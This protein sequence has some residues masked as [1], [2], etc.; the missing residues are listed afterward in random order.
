MPATAPLSSSFPTSRGFFSGRPH[1]WDTFSAAGATPPKPKGPELESRDEVRQGTWSLNPSWLDVEPAAPSA[2]TDRESV[3][4]N[5]SPGGIGLSNMSPFTR[6]GFRLPAVG[7]GDWRSRPREWSL[8]AVGSGRR[9]S[10]LWGMGRAVEED[11]EEEYIQTRSGATSRRHSVAAFS[12]HH[13]HVGFSAPGPETASAA[14]SSLRTS[15]RFNDDE[16]AADLNSLH[17]NLEAVAG[18]HHQHGDGPSLSQT[19]PRMSSLPNPPTS[20][21]LSEVYEAQASSPPQP[22]PSR[23]TVGSSTSGDPLSPSA[24]AAR[25]LAQQQQQQQAQQQ[26]AAAPSSPSRGGSRFDFGYVGPAASSYGIPPQLAGFGTNASQAQLPSRFAGTAPSPTV[27]YTGGG[28]ARPLPPVT[29]PFNAFGPHQPA[30]Y[31][32]QPNAQPDLS[33][34]GKGIPLGSVPSDMP[35]YIVEF[36]AGRTDLFYLPDP[37]APGGN[38]LSVHK[39]DLVIV[40]ADRGKD[41][42]KVVHD[43]ITLAEVQAFQQHQVE[44]AIGQLAAA[45]AASPTAAGPGAVTAQQPAASPNAQTIARMT[46]EIHPKKIFAKATQA[47]IQMLVTKA[48]DEAKALALVRGKVIQKNLPMEVTDCEW[49]FGEFTYPPRR[50]VFLPRILNWNGGYY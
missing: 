47:D 19:L 35:L 3:T 7:A 42:G 36:K 44:Q 22:T 10:E 24:T 2:T 13:P 40:E 26:A 29:S 1:V 31:G 5:G 6:D 45:S 38:R 34:L 48:N 33:D 14:H 49:Q 43:S 9:R 11:E 17:L 30:F 28:P 46:R 8:G 41:L 50:M 37:T 20:R 12:G 4:S 16:L 27:G 23:P 18:R 39:G 25:F 21:F 32:A 15:S